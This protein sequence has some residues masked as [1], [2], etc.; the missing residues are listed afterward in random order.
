MKVSAQ[1]LTGTSRADIER[2]LRAAGKELSQLEPADLAMLEDF[3]T[4]GRLATGQLA[5][6]AGISPLSAVLD[7]GTGIGGTARYVADRFGCLV[8]A[9]DLSDDYVATAQWL[10]DLVGLGDRIVVRPGDVTALPFVD[11]AFD[12]VFSQHVQMNVERKDEL[13]RE[14]RRVLVAGGR[15]V[16]W[17]VAAGSGDELE[18]PLPWADAAANSHLVTPAVLRSMVE[19]AGFSIEHWDDLTEEAAST[20]RV[21][22]SLPPSPLGLHAFVPNFPERAAHLTEALGD[23]RLRAIRAVARA[24]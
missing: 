20:M 11:G 3:H 21:V 6:L 17:D 14:A 24:A 15:L 10:N 8:T 22:G 9:I 2:A 18:Y 12:V 23:G 19:S 5:E 16:I 7:A 4:I 1:Y 13:Y